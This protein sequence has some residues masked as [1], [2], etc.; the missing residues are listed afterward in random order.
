MLIG[1]KAESVMVMQLY[2]KQRCLEENI[3][4][5]IIY[6]YF[7]VFSI[8]LHVGGS[9]FT[10]YSIQNCIRMGSVIM[11]F[12]CTGIYPVNLTIVTLCVQTLAV[13]ICCWDFPEFSV[14]QQLKCRIKRTAGKSLRLLEQPRVKHSIL[15]GTL[16]DNHQVLL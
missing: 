12:V 3:V 5:M 13:L 4:K 7:S 10:P 9:I 1:A 8:Q 15:A 14:L 11:K 16:G 6:G 2:C